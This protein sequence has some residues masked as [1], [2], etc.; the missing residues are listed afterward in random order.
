MQAQAY[1]RIK[2]EECDQ[3]MR[4]SCCSVVADA[5]RLELRA[6][7]DDL[8]NLMQVLAGPRQLRVVGDQP[9]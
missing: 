6:L 4:L 5:A 2:E 1:E 9:V 3:V 8:A 7:A